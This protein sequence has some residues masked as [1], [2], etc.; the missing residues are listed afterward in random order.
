MKKSL[1]SILLFTGSLLA[2]EPKAVEKLSNELQNLLSLEMLQIEKGM[3]KIFSHIIRGE[4]EQINK[5]AL[6]IRD[7]FILRKKLT[8][9]QRNEIKQLPKAFL[10]LDH[11][12]HETAGDLA[13]AAEFGDKDSVVEYYQ[14]MTAKC[15][16][17]HSKFATFRFKSFK[18]D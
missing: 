15:V 6:K 11:S 17:C 8:K 13:N 9:A 2:E 7:S 4:Y 3:H 16:Q 5:S 14:K 1:L 10:E 18:E 12:F